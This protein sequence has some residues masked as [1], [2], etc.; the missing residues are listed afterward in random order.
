M[1]RSTSQENGCCLPENILEGVVSHETSPSDSSDEHWLNVQKLAQARV[2]IEKLERDLE[3]T[4]REN[5]NLRQSLSALQ[6]QIERIYE[7]LQP[8]FNVDRAARSDSESSSLIATSGPRG[9]QPRD[10][11][12]VEEEQLDDVPGQ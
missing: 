7:T 10:F 11:S 4:K 3:C 8:V 9:H 2:K 1:Y 6:Y 5:A 12:A